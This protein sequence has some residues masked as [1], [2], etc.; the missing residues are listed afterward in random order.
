MKVAIIYD[1]ITGNTKKLADVIC[2]CFNNGVKIYKEYCDEILNFDLIFVGSWTDK[3]E[4]SD[5]I[6]KVYKNIHGKKIFVFGTCGFGGSDNYFKQLFERTMKYINEDN[7]I[8]G[9]YF[10]P[11]KISETI[12]NKYDKILETNPN[13]LKTVKMLNNFN[14]VSSRPNDDD[15]DKFEQMVRKISNES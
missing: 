2:E 4:P 9:Y 7:E 15:L 10:C 6:K 13:D 1:S 8:V 12:K 3:G 11:G 14:A 5:K